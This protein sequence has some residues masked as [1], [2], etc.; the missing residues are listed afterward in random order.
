[1]RTRPGRRRPSP[2]SG[3]ARRHGLRVTVPVLLLGL[4]LAGCNPFYVARAGWAQAK[5]LASR[6]PLPQVIADPDTDPEMRDR[7]RLVWDARGFATD[8]LGFENVGD[9]YTTLARLPSDTLALVLSAAYRDRL[10]FRTWWFPI[11]GRVPYR[12]Y[13]SEA[14]AFRARDRLEAQGFDTYLRPTAAFSTLGWFADPVYSTLLRQDPVGVV[15]TI[16]HELAHNHLFLAGQG[17]FNES[18]ATF[19]GHAASIEFFCR[20]DGGGQDT[21]RCRRAR[22]RWVDARIVSHFLMELEEE[23]RGIYADPAL[24]T[25]EKIRRRGESYTRAQAHF[26]AEVQPTLIATTYQYLAREELNNATLLARTLYFHRLDDF[27]ELWEEG[28]SGDL[29][30][31]MA[32]LREE[33]P[34]H[35]DPFRVLEVGRLAGETSPRSLVRPGADRAPGAPTVP[36][37]Q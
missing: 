19:V 17:R 35:S 25:E 6:E 28:W 27:H 5:I 12:A 37:S 16:L 3:P 26:V 9:S 21:I 18:Y 15:E 36:D 34:R 31:L 20:R 29:K 11:T 22:D 2:G 24:P 13:F 8:E 14:G 33:A 10:A 32:W 30:A 4:L 1:M 7:L 23:V